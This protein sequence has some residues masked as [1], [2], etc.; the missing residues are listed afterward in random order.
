LN[1]PDLRI[2]KPTSFSGSLLDEVI[3]LI[4]LG[5]QVKVADA[6]VGVHRSALVATMRLDGQLVATA[7]FKNPR[8]PYVERVFQEA[9]VA[10]QAVGYAH[11]LGY[12]VTRPGFEGLG[13]CKQLLGGLFSRIADQPMFATTRKPEMIHILEKHGFSRC[14]EIYKT[15]LQL[16]VYQPVI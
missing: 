15:D 11:E 9:K 7:G 16:F 3:K 2:D 4:I 6:K 14:G 10:E 1:T 5:G 8:Q 12:I 13:F